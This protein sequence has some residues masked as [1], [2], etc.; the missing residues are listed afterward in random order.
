MDTTKIKNKLTDSTVIKRSSAYYEQH[1]RWLPLVS[2]IAGFSWDNLTLNRIDR[3]LDNMIML[4][5]L[6]LLGALIV[7][8]HL[9]DSGRI[10]YE[11]ISK[12]RNLFP[13]GIQFFFGSLFSS[14]VVFYFQSA[15]LSENWLFLVFLVILLVVNEF[16]KDRYDSLR[17]NMALYFMAAFS[18]SIFF[19]PVVLKIMNSLIFFISGFLALIF[20]LTILYFLCKEKDK[21]DLALFKKTGILISGLFIL[22][23]L[24]YFFNWIPPVPLSLKQGG[25]YHHVKKEGDLYKL[26]FEK[27]SWYEFLKDSDDTF[28]FSPGDTVFCFA[29]VFAPTK[30]EKKIYFHWQFY[31]ERKE[32]WQSTDRRNYRITGGREGG[33]RG[34]TYKRNMRAGDWRID[35]ET[36]EKALLG[37]ITFTVVMDSTVKTKTD[38][39]TIY[40]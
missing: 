19:V 10:N 35:V 33:Y 1:K 29:S 24:L 2:F 27:G 32:E 6:L 21:L 25:I 36:G 7:L 18:F 38:I 13:V 9:V 28:N 37:R 17:L 3:F 40:N 20:I 4:L 22:L 26:Q 14:Y 12:R 30:L 39:E 11:Q 34:Y 23:N 8:N 5:Y 31:N 16:I 15:S